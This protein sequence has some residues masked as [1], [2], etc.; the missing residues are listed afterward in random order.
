[1]WLSRS[2]NIADC[3]IRRCEI[4]P[5]LDLIPA[6]WCVK[7]FFSFC[8]STMKAILAFLDLKRF[9]KDSNIHFD[10]SRLLNAP[11]P[12][13]CSW[14][15]FVR[16]NRVD[17]PLIGQLCFAY[18]P[19]QGSYMGYANFPPTPIDYRVAGINW[20][21]TFLWVGVSFKSSRSRSS[22]SSAM[23]QL[24]L[25]TQRGRNSSPGQ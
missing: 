3:A 6:Y 16:S 7:D 17:R 18:T 21:I 4:S 5:Q 9:P 19:L 23:S 8:W 20:P 2:G 24:M 12:I 13:K 14:R 25:N 10:C 15:T 22:R 11:T 1:M